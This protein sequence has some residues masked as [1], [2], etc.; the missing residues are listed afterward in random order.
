MLSVKV[1]ELRNLAKSMNLK[2]KKLLISV[3]LL[4]V[5]TQS[6]YAAADEFNPVSS[7]IRMLL[8]LL[9]VLAIILGLY[10]LLRNRVSAFNQQGKGLIKVVEIRHVL[11]K[12]TLMLIE[13]RGREFIVGAGSDTISTIV[14][15]ESG[16]S[17]AAV[18]EQSE[19]KQQS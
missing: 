12:K 19:E 1:T 7:G 13:V 18:L 6:A 9:V 5:S 8:G 4:A 16:E 3:L 14:P 10:Y 17:F 2:A 15:L 11:P